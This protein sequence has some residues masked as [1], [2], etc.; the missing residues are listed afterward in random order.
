MRITSHLVT[1]GK[2]VF[3]GE[4]SGPDHWQVRGPLP[5]CV[6]DRGEPAIPKGIEFIER[7][8]EA[9]RDAE[10]I[11]FGEPYQCWVEYDPCQL[12]RQA[13][14]LVADATM[15]EMIEG[16]CGGGEWRHVPTGTE[17][18]VFVYVVDGEPQAFLAP[19]V[20]DGQDKG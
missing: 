13:G 14:S 3:V 11:A 6:S 19:R 2:R 1:Y 10:P 4:W 15:V 12:R 17:R 5:E 8:L 18:G 20:P 7:A 9:A 16:H